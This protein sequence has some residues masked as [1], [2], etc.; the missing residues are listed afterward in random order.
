MTEGNGDKTPGGSVVYRHE[1]VERG[2]DLTDCDADA[3]EKIE[4]HIAKYIGEPANVFHEIVSDLVHID[5]HI[6]GPTAARDWYTLVTSGMSDRPMT[7]P[8]GAE[9]FRF[10]ELM[11]S[12]PADWSTESLWKADLKDES[13][14]WPIRLLK[15]LARLPHEYATWLGFGHTVPNGDPPVRYAPNTELCCALLLLP[16]TTDKAFHALDVRPGKTVRF[17]SVVPI[18]E[19]EKEYKLKKGTSALTDCFDARG[20]TELLDPQRPI[21]AK[22]KRF[23]LF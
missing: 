6:V 18:Y 5:V 21:A 20:V 4:A 19:S 15:S 22:N 14:Y 1:R 10:A 17:Y 7:V 12:L 3:I 13:L 9:D 16:I 2:R 8:E 11:L 23:L